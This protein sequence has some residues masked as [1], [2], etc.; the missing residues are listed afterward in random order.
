MEFVPVGKFLAVEGR[1]QAVAQAA[2]VLALFALKLVFVLWAVRPAASRAAFP[3]SV[4]ILNAVFG[5]VVWAVAAG[6][7]EHGAR[8]PLLLPLVA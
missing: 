5:L 2:H 1:V 8:Q 7:E 4:S 6:D 3:L